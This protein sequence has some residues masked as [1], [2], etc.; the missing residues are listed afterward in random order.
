MVGV[1][2]S[3]GAEAAFRIAV[4]LAGLCQGSVYAV[5]VMP[6]RGQFDGPIDR[7]QPADSEAQEIATR[8]VGRNI[9]DALDACNEICLTAGVEFVREVLVGD[10]VRVLTRE[11]E[12]AEMLVI[13][14][15][16]QRNDPLNLLGSTAQRVLRQS[17]KPVLVVRGAAEPFQRALVGYDGTP[18]AGHAVEWTADFARDG[19]W[20]VRMV[21]G[22]H[23][24]SYLASGARRAARIL[25]ARG[26]DPDVQLVEGDAPGILF[27]H[28]K[29]FE[30]DLIVIGA[31][32]KGAVTG[33]FIGEAWPDVVEQAKVSVLCW[34]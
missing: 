1:D 9:E 8:D 32:P 2:G 14:A 23:P 22:A 21:T 13:G 19:G 7:R 5:A 33:F 30:A 28:A 16:G 6:E 20:Q 26:L 4:D 12:G 24:E 34:R 27:E 11:A 10:P 3:P 17:I 18:D 25:E 31:A 15:Q 29:A